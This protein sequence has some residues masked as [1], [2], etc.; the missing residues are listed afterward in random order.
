MS[1]LVQSLRCH[2]KAVVDARRGLHCASSPKA[3]PAWFTPLFFLLPVFTH[4]FNYSQNN[5][6]VCSCVC[7]ECRV[8]YSRVCTCMMC[9]HVRRVYP[10]YMCLWVCM[11]VCVI[12]VSGVYICMYFVHV[13]VFC[14]CLCACLFMV[15]LMSSAVLAVV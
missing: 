5:S 8:P 1:G 7:N 2:L 4:G 11:R 12:P 13:R 3:R 6:H 14:M 15:S 10:Y 9:A